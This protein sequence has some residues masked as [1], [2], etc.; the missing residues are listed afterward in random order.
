M[1]NSKQIIGAMCVDIPNLYNFDFF[2]LIL[3]NFFFANRARK[4]TIR[5]FNV[6]CIEEKERSCV[7]TYNIL[8]AKG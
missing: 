1:L 5:E 2:F 3:I 4:L 6:K 8:Y 7:H